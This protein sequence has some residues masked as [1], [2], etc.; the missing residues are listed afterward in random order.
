MLLWRSPCILI[1]L[2]DE[3][4]SKGKETKCSEEHPEGFVFQ[5]VF[6]DCYFLYKGLTFIILITVDQHVNFDW[7]IYLTQCLCTGR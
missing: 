4:G 6:F 2:H 7:I 5:A 3:F 1:V